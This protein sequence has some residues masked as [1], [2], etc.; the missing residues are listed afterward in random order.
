M[1]SFQGKPLDTAFVIEVIY[2]VGIRVFSTDSIKIELFLLL[3]LISLNGLFALSE[4]AIVSSRKA[5]LDQL[6]KEGDSRARVALDLANSPDSFL[7]TIQIG[8]TF[9]GI[10]AGAFGGATIAHAFAAFF[11]AVPLLE[12]YSKALGLGL[13]VIIITY[14]SLVIGELVPKRLALNNPERIARLIAPFI[15][16]LSFLMHPLV[17]LLSSSTNLMLRIFR[18]K[19]STEPPV[20][21]EEIKQLIDQGTQAG[22]FHEFE[23][24]VIERVFRL[25][26]RRVAVLMTPRNDIVWLDL[27]E[28]EEDTRR[29]VAQHKY[30]FFPAARDSLDNIVGVISGKDLL[31][32]SMEAKPLTLKEIS[33]KPLFVSEIT[34]AVKVLE[35]FK[36][37]GTHIALV[38]DE[39]GTIQGLVTFD[40]ILGSLFEDVEAASEGEKEIIS[41]EDG[42]WLMVGSLPLDEFA[43]FLEIGALSEEE[44]A[45]M[46]T[47]GGFAMA[48]IGTVPSE[49]QHF[50]W[51]E[52]RIEVVDM[53]GRRVD[54]VLVSRIKDESK[55][56]L[57]SSK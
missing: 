42:S 41:R 3:L 1:S 29:I 18:V 43:D 57:N 46:I 39:Y 55:G 13:V 8:I 11:A 49:G 33:R 23:Q 44:R 45:G 27:N 26:D 50:N 28:S 56:V 7:P 54:K 12:R 20:T 6:A 32:L 25:A 4:L 16:G 22:T 48:R 2:K 19:P 36:K 38:V 35:L 24:D 10:L 5:R 9:V 21:E 52:F 34:P 31:S 15:R 40:D 30:S 53:D 51:R 14:L 47:L 37:S 17:V